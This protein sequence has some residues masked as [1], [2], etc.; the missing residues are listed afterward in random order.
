MTKMAYLLEPDEN[1]QSGHKNTKKVGP[2]HPLCTHS[3]YQTINFHGVCL[4]NYFVPNSWR[5]Y[6]ARCSPQFQT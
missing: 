5:K 2:V 6:K 3:T 1:S 4:I